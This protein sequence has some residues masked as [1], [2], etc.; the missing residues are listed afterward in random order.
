MTDVLIKAPA[1]ESFQAFVVPFSRTRQQRRMQASAALAQPIAMM[2]PMP[3]LE[4]K[5]MSL[6]HAASS[7]MAVE[8]NEFV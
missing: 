6:R 5:R 7:G 1:L 4:S 3:P 2:L 8:A